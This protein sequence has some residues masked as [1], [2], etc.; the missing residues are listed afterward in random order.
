MNTLPDVVV[1]EATPDDA[2]TVRT[3]IGEIAATRPSPA[4]S[5]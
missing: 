1:R 2:E 4:P 3:L 5:P